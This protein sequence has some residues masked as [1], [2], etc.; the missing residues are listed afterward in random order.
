LKQRNIFLSIVMV[1]FGMYCAA[2][3]DAQGQSTPTNAPIQTGAT[4]PDTALDDIVVTAQRREEHV[5]D[6]PLTIN[7]VSPRD[8]EAAG[9]TAIVGLPNLV[10]AINM[11]RTGNSL[12]PG[13]RGISTSITD[14]GAEPN[15]AI[16]VDGVYQPS[17]FLNVFD[18]PDVSRI[19][20]VKGPQGTLFG[21]NATGGAIE[22]FTRDPSFTTEGNVKASY[23]SFNETILQGFATGPLTDTV[24]GS[25]SLY[26]KT[27]STYLINLYPNVPVSGVDDS[28]ARAKLLFEPNSDAKIV[29]AA[30][31]S[32]Y[33]D[34]S[35]EYGSPLAGV[36]DAKLI[37]G[38]I[39]PTQPWQVATAEPL[40]YRTRTEAVDVHG[41]FETFAGTVS[42]LLAYNNLRGQANLQGDY[43]YIPDG[44]G[45]FFTYTRGD[46]ENEQA[47]I[48]LASKQYGPF[49]YIAG[50]NYFHDVNTYDP[51]L[52]VIDPLLTPAAF[53]ASL[54][55]RA[56]TNALGLFT[57]LSYSLTDRLT[58]LA[59]IRYST[60]T[61]GNYGNDE[62]GVYAR[63]PGPW[64]NFGSKT[65]VD[66]TP[67]ASL[68]FKI[69]DDTNAYF[70]YS[71]GF[72]SGLFQPTSNPYGPYCGGA[73]TTGCTPVTGQP[74]VKP[75][76]IDSYEV[77]LKTARSWYSANL[78]AYYY[79]YRD[80]Q[81]QTFETIDGVFSS[82]VTNAASSEIYGVEL[83]GTLQPIEGLRLHGGLAYDHARFSDFPNAATNVPN[84]TGT[85]NDTIVIDA[86]GHTP[87]RAPTWTA[88][89]SA[90]YTTHFNAGDA[91]LEANA[92]GSS[93]FYY[94]ITDDPLYSQPTYAT[95]GA[96]LSFVPRNTQL[97]L[98][99]WGRN[100][101][102]HAYEMGNFI[103][104]NASGLSY[105]PPRMLGVSAAYAF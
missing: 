44:G 32:I 9:V 104:A 54:F 8:L 90:S 48:T 64:Y 56:T 2:P 26:R 75:E 76:H 73:V 13:I 102:N 58:A 82:F 18:L 85:G 7:A 89:L 74:Y 65:F 60:E 50:V 98:A 24:A 21:R 63:I 88:T 39:I 17:S 55:A 19:D 69:T 12:D 42:T 80:Q 38:A 3:A 15:V 25:L 45:T 34:P 61:K 68:R 47:E 101:T 84:A 87:I 71:T 31:Y 92:Y 14:P 51:L 4:P 95:L 105:A 99:F 27:A 83:E 91:T 11:D 23:G 22:I 10:T 6:V 28:L 70:T 67:R 30:L 93:R 40:A 72:K 78:A 97:T 79:K 62:F 41:T 5:Q 103:Q 1:W 52:F 33:S 77:G 94:T 36:T 43:S 57:E 66:S 53:G 37:P 16:Y 35:A 96:Q 81:V 49:S 100:L 29:V 20:V 86:T 59:G 46:D